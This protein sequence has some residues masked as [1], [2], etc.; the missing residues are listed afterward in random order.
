MVAEKKQTMPEI[1]EGWWESV[2]AEEERYVSSS[3]KQ[4]KNHSLA[5]NNGSKPNPDWQEVR[6]LYHKDRIVEL[7]VTGYNRGGVLVEGEGL[8]GFVPYSHLVDLSAN[9]EKQERERGL[10]SYVGRTLRLKVIE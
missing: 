8:F 2:L 4:P 3:Q 9:L 10:E 7:K 6:D 5:K 1:D